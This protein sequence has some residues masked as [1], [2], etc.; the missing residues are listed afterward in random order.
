VRRRSDHPRPRLTGLEEVERAGQRRHGLAAAVPEVL[1]P[2]AVQGGPERGGRPRRRMGRLE[3]VAVVAP[4]SGLETRRDAPCTTG[5]RIGLE[6]RQR[7]A[8]YA[9]PGPLGQ[10]QA[11][12]APPKGHHL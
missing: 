1:V 8:A 11:F 12:A 10:A 9:E 3:A 5:R 4:R 2:E 7:G 6:Q